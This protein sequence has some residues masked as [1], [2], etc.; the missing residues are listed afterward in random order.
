MRNCIVIFSENVT[1]ENQESSANREVEN[2]ITAEDIN[3]EGL[4]NIVDDGEKKARLRNLT[5]RLW[6]II[7]TLLIIS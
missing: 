6:L 3:M 1:M 4:I 5:N 7:G 2:P